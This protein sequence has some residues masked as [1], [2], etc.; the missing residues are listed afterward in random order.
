MLALHNFQEQEQ[1]QRGKVLSLTRPNKLVNSTIFG[2]WYMTNSGSF[3][4]HSSKFLLRKK[5]ES[6]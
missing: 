6:N 3:K 4:Q 2:T 5:F 1:K